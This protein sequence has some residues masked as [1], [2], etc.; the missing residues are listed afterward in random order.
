MEGSRSMADHSELSICPGYNPFGN[1]IF[2]LE[3]ECGWYKAYKELVPLAVI[4]EDAE[5]HQAQIFL[6]EA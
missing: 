3:C 5:E 2:E 1:P 6:K 4:M